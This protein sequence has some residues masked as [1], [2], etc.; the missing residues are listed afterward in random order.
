MMKWVKQGTHG[1]NQIH[2]LPGFLG[3]FV[4]GLFDFKWFPHRKEDE[5]SL[6]NDSGPSPLGSLEF[7]KK[8]SGGVVRCFQK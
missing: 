8:N 3:P 7:F 4:V 5:P 1:W 2:G 6:A